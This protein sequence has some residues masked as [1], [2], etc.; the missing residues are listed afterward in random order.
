MRA[1]VL[2][3]TEHDLDAVAALVP[4]PVVSNGRVAGR[5]TCDAAGVDPLSR[6]GFGFGRARR[7]TVGLMR[8]FE[9]RG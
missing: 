6:T 7:G 4:T 9:L 5:P 1:P 8:G 2:E 3:A